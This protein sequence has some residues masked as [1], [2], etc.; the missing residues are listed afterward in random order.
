MS[1]VS[2]DHEVNNVTYSLYIAMYNINPIKSA[3]Y[4]GK[5]NSKLKSLDL[6]HALPM[7]NS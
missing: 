3:T 6:C 4:T 2:K 7:V 5:L 1:R